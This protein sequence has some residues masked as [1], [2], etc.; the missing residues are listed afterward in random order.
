MSALATRIAASLLLAATALHADPVD[1]FMQ[2]KMRELH[3]P[4][5]Q[6]AVVRDGKIIKSAAYG[7]ANLERKVKATEDTVF[8]I[9]SMT[10]QFTA[11]AIL[12]LREEEKLGLDDPIEKWFSGVPERWRGITIRHL[13]THSSGMENY[14]GAAGFPDISDPAVTHDQIARHL[15][16]HL[17]REFAP[18]ETWSYSNSGYLL[19]GNIIEKASGMSYFDFLQRRI[20]DPLGMTRTRSTDPRAIP[21]RRANGY[22][23]RNGT[24]ESR[25]ALYTNAYA[26]GAIASTARDLAKWDAALY[27]NKLVPQASLELMWTPFR[28]NGDRVAPFRYGFGWFVDKY[29]TRKVIA[30]SGGTPGFSSL[31]HRFVDDRLTVILLTNRADRVIDHLAVDIAGFYEPS[32]KRAPLPRDHMPEVTRRLRAVVTA[33]VRG[34]A[35]DPR[36]FT[37]PMGL[38]LATPGRGLY[39]WA[40]ADGPL[41]SFEFAEQE[42]TLDGK[43]LRY[44]ATLGGVERW[45]SVTITDE[46]R[47]AR[48]YPW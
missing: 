10:K 48:V 11:M 1:V 21:G 27:G 40:G 18:G 39:E 29:R 45:F 2:R 41:E 38:F 30:H 4:A 17:K 12:M 47:I 8:E 6:L 33:L 34:E 23:W 42:R 26:A 22:E 5:A 44:R 35:V 31:I 46:G 16:T 25:P 19:L 20:F 15:F 37:E 36:W 28:A 32:L 13:L 43:I 3:L 7:M 24:Y 14:L 9:G